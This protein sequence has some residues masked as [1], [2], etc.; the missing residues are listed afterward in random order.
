[1]VDRGCVTECRKGTQPRTHGCVKHQEFRPEAEER[2]N[3]CKAEHEDRKSGRQPFPGLRKARQ[4]CDVLNR[5]AILVAHLKNAHEAAQGHHTIDGQIAQDRGDA[6][7]RARS[8]A[9]KRETGIDRKSTRL[10]SSHK[11]APRMQSS[12]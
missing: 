7:L 6:F 12:E 2:W 11:Y 3:A 9:N 4:A 8:K 10:N 1:M 5:I